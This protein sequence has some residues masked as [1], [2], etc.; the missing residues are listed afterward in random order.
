MF[1]PS[2]VNRT[3]CN[4]IPISKDLKRFLLNRFRHL[5]D[6]NGRKYASDVFKDMR[7]VCLRYRADPHRLLRQEDYI[8]SF[9]CKRK[10]WVRLVF[11]YMDTQPMVMLDF[12]KLYCG[13]QSPT[14]SVEQ[15]T[16][17]QQ[18]YLETREDHV[19][20]KV[21]GILSTWLQGICQPPWSE[22]DVISW[23]VCLNLESRD[24]DP[25]FRFYKTHGLSATAEYQRKW[26]QI[27]LYPRIISDDEALKSAR[28]LTP[29]PELYKDFDPSSHESRTLEEDYWAF[30]HIMQKRHSG[31]APPVLSDKSIKY[32]SEIYSKHPDSFNLWDETQDTGRPWCP[33]PLPSGPIEEC[34]GRVHHIPKKGTVKRRPIAVPN[35]FIQAGLKPFQMQ[36]DAIVHRLP[37]DCTFNQGKFD[38]KIS[39]RVS[40]S[41]LYAGSV[42]LSQATD[43]LPRAWGW[44]ILITLLKTYSVIGRMFSNTVLG[45]LKL[46]E[47]VASSY[48]QNGD[49]KVEWTIGQPLGSL[50]SFDFLALTHNCLLEALSFS[51]GLAHSPYC[52]LGD[53]VLIFNKNLRKEYIKLMQSAG[54]PLSLQKSYSGNLVEF[55]GKIFIKNQLPAYSSDHNPITFNSLFDYQRSTGIIIPYEHL[56]SSL[57]RRINRHT[58]AC[59]LAASD[60]KRVYNLIQDNIVKSLYHPNILLKNIDENSAFWVELSDG[61]E[62]EI[63]DPIMDSGT[64][65]VSGHPVT[66][67]DYGYAEK[68]GHLQRFRQITLPKW[69]KDKVRP[70]TT[71][72][73]IS[74][75]VT[76]L[77][78]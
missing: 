58:V 39:G 35:R 14:V 21:P 61:K 73:L 64:V 47:E 7:E 63:P 36:L 41:S 78:G 8:H 18:E 27:L 16:I 45:S 5:V 37:K 29:K 68:H 62:S 17:D 71:E 70:Y 9:P 13:M 67:G 55:A 49:Y 31:F 10:G 26:R 44:S 76:A 54:I 75:A 19:N 40:N 3:I 30:C 57:K 25:W 77:R 59:G 32:L 46:F 1:I 28:A 69:Y 43:N 6:C 4:S 12:L 38:T 23:I 72:R 34:V 33:D 65:T 66:F 15:S 52:V 50:P 48:W 60:S 20:P 42:D 2:Y 74:C 56:N 51:R 22:D 11:R 24:Q 53:D